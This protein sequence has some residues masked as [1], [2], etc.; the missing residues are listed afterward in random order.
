[1]VIVASI[2]FTCLVNLAFALFVYSDRVTLA[3][4]AAEDVD[5]ILLLLNYLI[6]RRSSSFSHSSCVLCAFTRS[7]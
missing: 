2:S 1:M 3:V 6:W 7:S 5:D 4:A